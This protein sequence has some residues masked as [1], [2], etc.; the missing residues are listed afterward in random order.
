MTKLLLVFSFLLAA[1]APPAHYLSGKHVTVYYT[2]KTGI[3]TA[4]NYLS[5]IDK[6]YNDESVKLGI[7]AGGRLRARICSDVYEY[8]NYTQVDTFLAPLFKDGVLYII[9]KSSTSDPV[10]RRRLETAV[11]Q[12]ILARIRYNGAP[13]W[14]VY[15]AAVYESGQYKDLT[16]PTVESVRYFADLD[17]RIQDVSTASELSDLNYYLGATGRFFD[18]QYGQ[19][20]LIKLIR[21]FTH[22]TTI[23]DAVSR[24]FHD[25]LDHVETT[26]HDYISG[27]AGK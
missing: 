25:N 7:G 17:E 1:A 2:P 19:G 11:V 15:S 21:Q 4:R 3:S 20:S 10:Y 13:W 16:P 12:G 18:A 9:K 5:L 24:M 14:L 8:S 22:R 6:M 23:N 26:W 27:T